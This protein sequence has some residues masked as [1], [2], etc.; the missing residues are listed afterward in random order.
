MNGKDEPIQPWSGKAGEPFRAFRNRLRLYLGNKTD[1]SGSSVTNYLD[2]N[3]MGGP[4]PTAPPLPGGA[5]AADLLR[6]RRVRA[7][8]AYSTILS[9]IGAPD[10]QLNLMNTYSANDAYE[11]WQHLQ[12]MLY[13]RQQAPRRQ[14]IG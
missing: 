4:L 3:D 2:G 1:K 12:S 7:N 11:M 14:P 8:I 13:V 6:L 9:S 5:A 10:I